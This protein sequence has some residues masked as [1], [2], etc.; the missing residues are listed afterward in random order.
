MSGTRD[1]GLQPER[2]GLSWTR[3]AWGLLLN[4]V[5]FLRI[6]YTSES[7][8]LVGLSCAL[9]AVAGL[10]FGFGRIRTRALVGN[11][12]E[13]VVSILAIRLVAVATLLAALTG[14]WAILL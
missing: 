5:V 9:I 10:T 11:G 7:F 13:A 8:A 12:S 14:L 2:T 4:A 3:T 1:A 6:G